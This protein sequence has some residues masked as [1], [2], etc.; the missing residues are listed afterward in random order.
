M[1]PGVFSR[2][3]RAR[4]RKGKQMKNYKV[5][6]FQATITAG[7]IRLTDKQARP[8]M[9]AL[10]LVQALDATGK[11]DPK[12]KDG[13]VPVLGDYQVLSPVNFKRLEEFGWDGK[14]S[15]LQQSQQFD[16]LRAANEKIQQQ[17]KERVEKARAGN[18]AG[19]REV[20]APRGN[21]R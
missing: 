13:A 5:H 10:K 20:R 12:A 4:K 11:P 9:L 2:Q 1:Q 6:G 14:A 17:E 18:G 3:R 7:V 16:E 21:L 8:R 15:R 19:G